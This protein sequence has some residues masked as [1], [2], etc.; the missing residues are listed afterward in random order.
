MDQALNMAIF[1]KEFRSADAVAQATASAPCAGI[2]RWIDA[3]QH[4]DTPCAASIAPP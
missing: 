2:A 3:V 4:A 1:V